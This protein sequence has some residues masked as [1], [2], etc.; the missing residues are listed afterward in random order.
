MCRRHFGAGAE[1]AVWRSK[2]LGSQHGA[3]SAWAAGL[4]TSGDGHGDAEGR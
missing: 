2:S 3:Q 4:L 1:D